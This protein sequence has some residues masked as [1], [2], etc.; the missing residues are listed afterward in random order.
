VTSVDFGE[1]SYSLDRELNGYG[2]L[3]TALKWSQ[4]KCRVFKINST[5]WFHEETVG[6][7]TENCKFGSTL[8]HFSTVAHAK[9]ENQ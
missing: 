8:V 6:G 3:R 5:N 2:R 7:A 9:H 1:P 4:V